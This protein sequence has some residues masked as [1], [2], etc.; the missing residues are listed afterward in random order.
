MRADLAFGL[1][2]LWLTGAAYADCLPGKYAG[3]GGEAGQDPFP[4]LVTIACTGD[5]VTGQIESPF[6]VAPIVRGETAPDRWRVEANFDGQPLTAEATLGDGEW[7]GAYALAGSTGQLQLRRD[8]AATFAALNAEQPERTNLS[9]EEWRADLAAL[10]REIPG[11]HAN[12]FHTI[13][14]EAWTAAVADVDERLPTLTP[15]TAP[16]A[17]RE[18]AARIG[19]GHTAVRLPETRRLPIGMFWFGDEL[20]IVQ[21]DAAHAEL[22]GARV[23]RI[24]DRSVQDA[25]RAAQR[26]IA[27]ENRWADLAATPY[28]LRRED[29]L[30]YFGMADAGSVRLRVRRADG[31]RRDVTL[32][33]TDNAEATAFIGGAPPIWRQRAGESLWWQEL[34][35]GVFYI[36]FR[37]YDQLRTKSAALFAEID[38]LQP[39][40]VVLD[41][42]DNGGGDFT[43]FRESVLA[44]IRERAWLNQPDRL[45]VI[46][47]REMFSAA[48]S[49]AADLR[50]R[51][52]ATLVGE[53]IGERPNS[54]QEVRFFALPN[55]GLRVGVSVEYYEA[56]PGAGNPDAI[57]PDVSTPP[58]WRR[59]RVGE[60]DALEWIRSRGR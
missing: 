23:V 45:Y 32:A 2:W 35:G 48:M 19:D 30:A 15:A 13:D 27:R 17:L 31:A 11:R 34:P 5:V 36:N 46:I 60:D 9:T 21:T 50:L 56:L 49:N 53:P 6:G 59:F 8:D 14:R 41:M 42:R 24:G 4:V 33:F 22:L 39:A 18:L 54:Y 52:S 10:A 12:A 29:V 37:A 51:T 38:R 28:L 55:S 20:R 3:S 44:A 7:R 25:R 1:A 47:G 16:V 58:T 26:L 57:E 43:V 40:R